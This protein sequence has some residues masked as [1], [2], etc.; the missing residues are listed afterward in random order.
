M[1]T[2]LSAE[3]EGYAGIGYHYATK[4]VNSITPG[5]VPVL[6]PFLLFLRVPTNFY[7]LTV[8]ATPFGAVKAWQ[9]QVVTQQEKGGKRVYRK[10]SEDEKHQLYMQSMLG[11]AM[12]GY[13]AA[14]ALAGGDDKDAF[15]TGQGNPDPQARRQALANG[16]MPNSILI[17]GTN[18]RVS[19]QN[20]PIAMP[21]SLAAYVAD[22]IRYDKRP[23]TDTLKR[24][25]DAIVRAPSIVFSAPV[26]QGLAQLAEFTNPYSTGTDKA[27]RFLVNIPKSIVMPRFLN[28]MYAWLGDD[29][30]TDNGATRYDSLGEPVRYN[31]A[32]RQITFQDKTPL[33]A[34][35][36]KAS[37]TVPVPGREVKIEGH[38]Y[39]LTEQEFSDLERIAGGRTRL[40]L[41]AR[42][43]ALKSMPRDEAE[44]QVKNIAREELEHAR[45]A[46]RGKMRANQLAK[47]AQSK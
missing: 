25:T 46:M 16:W 14:K 23:D 11:S 6:K 42:L 1:S 44:K 22:S 45:E 33:R 26:L 27:K 43:G 34:W 12:M 15:L 36:N 31:P 32:G 20:W 40:R 30:V 28:Q 13:L 2:T 8:N 9:G 17:P 5:G 4:L 3:P 24:V 18:T 29:T 41:E 39:Q 35:L 19:Y 38:P 47:K 37:I 7:N 10:F 21:L